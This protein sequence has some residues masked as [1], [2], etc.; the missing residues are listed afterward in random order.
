GQAS[1]R[2]PQNCS[3][4]PVNCAFWDFASFIIEHYDPNTRLYRQRLIKLKAFDV[5]N[6]S[7][8]RSIE[9]IREHIDQLDHEIIELL[10]KRFGFVKEVV[11]FK[12]P[13]KDS[14]IAEERKNKVLQERRNLAMKNGLNPDIIENIYRELIE[15]F[16]SEELKIINRK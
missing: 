1:L 16:I 12:K 5:K 7:D 4:T 3:F 6:P 15:Y 13:D 14:I 2:L 10:G 9:E 11:K 8:C